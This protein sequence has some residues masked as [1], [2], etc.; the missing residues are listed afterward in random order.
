MVRASSQG[1]YPVL[2]VQV[3]REPVKDLQHVAGDVT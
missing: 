1:S 3:D 2:N